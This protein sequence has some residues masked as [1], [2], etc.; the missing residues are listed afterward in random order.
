MRTRTVFLAHSDAREDA[1]IVDLFE[2]LLRAFDME[3]IRYNYQEPEQLQQRIPEIIAECDGVVA[4]ATKRRKLDGAIEW[5]TSPWI[6]NELTIASNNR[7][8]TAVFAERDVRLG[9]LLAADVRVQLFER[10]DLST[11]LDKIV[12]YLHRFRELIDR[13]ARDPLTSDF[14]FL[15]HY[16][17][18]R[19]KIVS[20]EVEV[21]R[22]EILMESFTDNLMALS[23]ESRLF[24]TTPGVSIRAT[25]FVVDVL[26]APAGVT[27]SA[28]TLYNEDDRFQ[29]RLVFSRPLVS[30]ERFQ[31][32]FKTVHQNTQ[33]F[34]S[35]ELERRL[36][37]G[38]YKYKEPMCDACDW[39]IRSPTLALRYDAE[40][41]EGYEIA[42][43]VGDAHYADHRMIDEAETRR[44]REEKMLRYYKLV[45]Q[46]FIALSVER[47]RLG[48][49]YGVRYRPGQ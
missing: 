33:P 7:K 37:L 44:M 45:D 47:P 18:V 34:T 12:R 1:S 21:Q 49:L 26:S 16:I 22:V 14:D 3:V 9:G 24:D 38:T 6:E 32:A 5:L 31:Y 15:R 40:F 29:W 23:H 36:A 30:G 41:P 13:V 43:V 28:E 8:P 27:A 20:P 39:R 19:H 10:S 42:D 35:A 46:W 11:E 25:E 17:V 48:R 4:V 2:R